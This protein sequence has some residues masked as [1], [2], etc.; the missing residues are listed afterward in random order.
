MDSKNAFWEAFLVTLAVF[1]IGIFVGASYEYGRSSKIKESMF[2]SEQS[3][4]DMFI[5]SKITNSKTIN[6]ETIVKSELKLADDI[7]K[8]ALLLERYESTEKI[9]DELE[10]VHRKY[11]LLRTLLWVDFREIPDDCKKNISSIVYL[12]EYK[13]KDQVK[14]A[15]SGVWSKVLLEVKNEMGDKVIL[16]PIAVDSNI[17]SLDVLVSKFNISEFPLIIL[18]DREIIYELTSSEEIK[19]HLLNKST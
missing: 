6:C 14:K 15:K 13:T 8:D 9:I 1:V 18:N 17:S 19:E 16:I 2:L 12:Y 7:Y 3:L 5:L 11:D 10:K 4:I